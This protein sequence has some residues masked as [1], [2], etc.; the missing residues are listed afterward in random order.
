MKKIDPL[1]NL[2]FSAAKL[3]DDEQID[4]MLEAF[5]K[6]GINP[7]K[8]L[9]NDQFENKDLIQ[10]VAS[11]SDTSAE[12]LRKILLKYPKK[13]S[14]LQ[15]PLYYFVSQGYSAEKMGLILS[16][17]SIDVFE[18]CAGASYSGCFVN[19]PV[20]IMLSEV[21]CRS[22]ASVETQKVLLK[23]IDR[24]LKLENKEQLVE[25]AMVQLAMII[26]VSDFEMKKRGAVGI[27][28]SNLYEKT[29]NSGDEKEVMDSEMGNSFLFLM[30]EKIIPFFKKNKNIQIPLDSESSNKSFLYNW[31]LNKK[32]KKI[33][34]SIGL[35]SILTLCIS[36]G[37][38]EPTNATKEFIKRIFTELSDA[39]FKGGELQVPAK[40]ASKVVCKT[41]VVQS[42]GT[43]SGGLNCLESNAFNILIFSIFNKIA[44]GK[45]DEIDAKFVYMELKKRLQT[46][47]V[48]PLELFN[49]NKNYLMDEC[50]FNYKNRDFNCFM[51]LGY[52]AVQGS[53]LSLE[54]VGDVL[55]QIAQ[56][57]FDKN[58]VEAIVE[59]IL[60][61]AVMGF[62]SCSPVNKT[63][64]S[65]ANYIKSTEIGEEIEKAICPSVFCK[66]LEK[67]MSVTSFSY[68]KLLEIVKQ[69]ESVVTSHKHGAQI[70]MY[71]F[72]FLIKKL[73]SQKEFKDGEELSSALSGSIIEMFTCQYKSK[74]PYFVNQVEF[75]GDKREFL[76]IKENHYKYMDMYE[77]FLEKTK[78]CMKVLSSVERNT[79]NAKMDSTLYYAMSRGLSESHL[80]LLKKITSI[81]LKE[82]V[83]IDLQTNEGKKPSIKKNVKS[84]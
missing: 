25:A 20:H 8:K 52:S 57:D 16:T 54:I 50:G 58:R 5:E 27:S 17:E 46:L 65:V 4:V 74:S 72:S 55:K 49:F 60:R 3:T 77:D 11:L 12:F 45:E 19:T 67:L 31:L 61:G 75:F 1:V 2:V 6:L 64:K 37:V 71:L 63:V 10:K 15:T 38:G 28:K 47:L 35:G 18:P 69:E 59:S 81:H 56:P 32:T 24:V 78:D 14:N 22:F 73:K 76:R 79:C 70:G 43:N 40:K 29:N 62:E 83:E 66:N 80:D 53:P 13:Y 39:S 33:N 48:E 84:L 44:N 34:T 7:L 51:A 41:P 23:T 36:S 26:A 42:L 82:F 9:P 21:F 68:K 30:E